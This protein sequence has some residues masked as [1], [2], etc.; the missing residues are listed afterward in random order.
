MQSSFSTIFPASFLEQLTLL[1]QSTASALAI[2]FARTSSHF[3]YLK[4][5][6]LH[7]NLAG[8]PGVCDIKHT[9]KII[10]C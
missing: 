8:S 4:A 9:G 6:G 3:S 1:T 10:C 7:P 5:K 2:V